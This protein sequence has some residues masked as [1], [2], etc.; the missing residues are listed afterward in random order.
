MSFTIDYSLAA[1][2]FNI[3]TYCIHDGPG[4][5]STVFVKG[6]PLKCLWCANPESQAARPEL[7]T[8]SSKCTGCGRCVFV[9]P[10][11]AIT[12]KQQEDGKYVAV[13]DRSLCTDCG[14]CVGACPADAREL[15]GK[16]TTVR[17][18]VDKV[19]Q[20]KLFYD[21]SGGGI[22]I[23]GGEALAHHD[24]STH[25][26]AAS[27]AEG[28]HTAI[29]TSCFAR[30][31]VIDQVFAH[32]DLGLLDVKHMD[33]NIHRE[34][35]GVPNELILD[36]IRHIHCDLHV[37]VILRVPTIPGYNDSKVNIAAVGKFAAS[38]GSDVEVNLLP[39]HRLGESKSESLGRPN[40]LGIEPP[41]NEYM[42]ELK[43]L[44]E[45]HGVKTK[46]GG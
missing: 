18:A 3:Q 40:E 6:C 7:M 34:L 8:Y 14:G 32:V 10:A 1:P 36:N 20:D 46:I 13:T 15:A 19:K 17:E 23:S 41:S 27:H 42:E 2:V 35:T 29:E 43:A 38:L 4:I 5:R 30:R 33:N 45:S 28:I 31:E 9:C 21:G 37:P 26:F 11:K 44:V 39:Y 22:T 16:M 25:L 12:V 24:F